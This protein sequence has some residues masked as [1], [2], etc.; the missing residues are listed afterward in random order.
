VFTGSFTNST[1]TIDI[2]SAN[3]AADIN[4]G[5]FYIDFHTTGTYSGTLTYQVKLTRETKYEYELVFET[6]GASGNLTFK[7]MSNT[8]ITI[9]AV[10]NFLNGVILEATDSI[11]TE[12]TLD[13]DTF[14][15]GL[16]ADIDLYFQRPGDLYGDSGDYLLLESITVDTKDF[17]ISANSSIKISD[18]AITK[19]EPAGGTDYSNLKLINSFEFINAYGSD[20]KTLTLD[21]NS[22]TP[23]T[24]I[25]CKTII[26]P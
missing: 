15:T 22:N 19:P 5:R 17:T 8:D 13:S 7:N 3:M 4:D 14:A 16:R 25:F 26:I 11:I 10:N 9:K 23:I 12:I 20:T 1:T 2:S 21:E 6:N 18:F 24:K